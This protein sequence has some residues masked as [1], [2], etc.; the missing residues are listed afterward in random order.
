MNAHAFERHGV[1]HL[2]ASSL[3]LWAAQPALWIM[4]RLRDDD[5]FRRD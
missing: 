1:G 4:E 5:G 3:N 2:S